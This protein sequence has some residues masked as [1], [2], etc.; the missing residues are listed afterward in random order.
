MSSTRSY[1]RLNDEVSAGSGGFLPLTLHM[2]ERL[3]QLVP[4]AVDVGLHGAKWQVQRCRDLLVRTPFDVTQHDA[5]SILGAEP[6]DRPLDGASQ[7][8]RLHLVE[9]RLLLRRK[10]ERRRLHLGR[11]GGV[12]GAIDTDGV[13]LAFSEVIDRNVIG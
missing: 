6:C 3:T 4:R 10:V 7:L 5:G 11:R 1:G 12:R 8:T 13:E 2:L 9:R